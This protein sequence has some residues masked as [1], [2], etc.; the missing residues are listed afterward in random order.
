MGSN[1][2]SV[3]MPYGHTPKQPSKFGKCGKFAATDEK[4]FQGCFTEIPHSPVFSLC[5]KSKIVSWN[6]DLVSEYDLMPRCNR[7]K[8]TM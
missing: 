6:L 1:P 3:M 2:L 7:L 4:R 5:S 8:L